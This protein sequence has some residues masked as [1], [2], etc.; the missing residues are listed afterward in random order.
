M[1]VSDCCGALFT[2]PGYPFSD[3]CSEC[4]EH[5]DGY[6]DEEEIEWSIYEK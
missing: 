2:Y 3:I 6:E 5:A 1:I 4:N